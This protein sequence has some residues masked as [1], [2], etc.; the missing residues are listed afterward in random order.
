MLKNTASPKAF[1]LTASIR[2]AIK[3]YDFSFIFHY[4]IRI[5]IFL[6]CDD[7]IFKLC[8]ALD[9]HDMMVERN[10]ILL[11][12]S[13]SKSMLFV[14]VPPLCLLKTV[15]LCC[16]LTFVVIFFAEF[17]LPNFHDLIKTK[18][19]F[20]FVWQWD[21]E[22]KHSSPEGDLKTKKNNN[23]YCVLFKRLSSIR[24]FSLLLRE[25][26]EKIQWNG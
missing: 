4:F 3:I 6:W 17:V 24:S 8:I 14:P 5:K 20:Y 12:I 23:S 9:M 10:F 26:R 1:N 16:L 7:H 2:F 18:S 11:F 22:W 13:S 21:F 19:V 25:R 15:Y